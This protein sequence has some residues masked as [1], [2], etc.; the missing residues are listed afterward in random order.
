MNFEE[1]HLLSPNKLSASIHPISFRQWIYVII[2]TLPT[3][4]AGMSMGFSGIA[5]PELNLNLAQSSW[6][7]SLPT[8]GSV[9]GNF[10]T[11]Y[12]IDRLG[13]KKA[14][15]INTIPAFI[16]YAFLAIA[17]PFRVE[18]LYIGQ[19]FAGI[20]QGAVIYV[21]TVY[22][23]ES[24]A[25]DNLHFRSSLASWT[26]LGIIFGITSTYVSGYF[27]HY[28]S[29]AL[30]AASIALISSILVLVFVPESPAWLDQQ[31]RFKEAQRARHR[32]GCTHVSTIDLSIGGN[33]H[34]QDSFYS[35]LS[36][37]RR[38]DVYK[39]LLTTVTYF[40][41]QQFSGVQIFSAYMVN[42]ITVKSLAIDSYLTSLI[43]GIAMSLGQISYT[44]FLPKLGVRKIAILSSVLTSLTTLV[45]AICIHLSEIEAW[46]SHIVD[47]IHIVSVWCTIFFS[48]LGIATVPYSILGEIFPTDAKGFASIS[49]FSECVFYFIILMMHP[50]VVTL[51]SCAVFYVYAMIGFLAVPFVY[52]CIPETV[53]RTLEQVSSHYS[54]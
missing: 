40:F 45:L 12:V 36:K 10:L 1:K 9:L 6:F 24:M 30:I 50:R 16:G 22:I 8:V 37:V 52:W 53:G 28:D 42:T 44:V 14:F 47:Y 49:V 39:P 18:Y 35:Y 13:R 26:M 34:L 54:S 33:L 46:Y 32:L 20:S 25:P 21:T 2:L 51:S 23:A 7:A 27:F 4:P 17:G 41:F 31:G 5:L 48:A 29:V 15:F 11:G 19:L 3:L 38:K 43:G